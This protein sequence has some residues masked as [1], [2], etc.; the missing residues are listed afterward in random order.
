M[1]GPLRTASTMAAV[2][3]PQLASRHPLATLPNSMLLRSLFIAG[4]SS[5]RFLLLPSLK[6]LSFLSKPGRSFLFN[7]DRNPV[8]HGI[9][10]KTFY[11]QFCAGETGP[12]TKQCVRRLKDL[13]FKG[14]IL[15]YARETVF[16]HQTQKADVQGVDALEAAKATEPSHCPHIEEWRNGTLETVEL[17]DDNDF[18]AVK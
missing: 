14:V 10:K 2:G 3:S 17:I 5:K 4:I 15:T 6:I 9:L 18:L 8:V 1:K 11:D 13:G 12:E 7:V 16:D